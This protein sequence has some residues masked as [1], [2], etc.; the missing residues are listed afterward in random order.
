MI[1]YELN[2]S[3]NIGKFTHCKQD[4]NGASLK[5]WETADS[6]LSNYANMLTHA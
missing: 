6:L 4:K 1:H 5:S 3:I 2:Y